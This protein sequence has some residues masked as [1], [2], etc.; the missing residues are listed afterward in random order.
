MNLP[1]ADLRSLTAAF[2]LENLNLAYEGWEKSWWRARVTHSDRDRSWTV[3]IAFPWRNM[4]WLATDGRTLPPKNGDVWHLDF[5][6][7]NTYKESLP[8]AA[9]LRQLMTARGLSTTLEE[10]NSREAARK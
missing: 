7:F 6:R 2:L 1:E 8:T 5:S 4:K 10:T 3:E 9:L